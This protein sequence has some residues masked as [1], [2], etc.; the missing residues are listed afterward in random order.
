MLD[1]RLI[2]CAG[3]SAA[4]DRLGWLLFVAGFAGSAYFVD[5]NLE[6]VH[7]FPAFHFCAVELYLSFSFHRQRQ[8]FAN[9]HVALRLREVSR[10]KAVVARTAWRILRGRQPGADCTTGQRRGADH[11]ATMYFQCSLG[12]P[13]FS[14]VAGWK[15]A[16]GVGRI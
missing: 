10:A 6:R 16:R 2:C 14:I 3:G 11:F 1:H 15:A 4:R 9:N 7:P 8:V 5:E 13:R 12:R